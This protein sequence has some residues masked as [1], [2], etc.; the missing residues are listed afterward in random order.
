VINFIVADRNVSRQCARRVV[1][2]KEVPKGKRREGTMVRT[3]L[4]RELRSAAAGQ[5]GLKLSDV[6]RK[7]GAS[8][9]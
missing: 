9:V 7:K 6:N 4:R 8:D 1:V 5:I 3:R 2:P